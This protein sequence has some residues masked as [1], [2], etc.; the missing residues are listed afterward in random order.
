MKL[1]S[2]HIEAMSQILEDHGVHIE[3]EKV[4]AIASDFKEHLS[5]CSDMEMTPH[6]NYGGESDHSKAERLEKRVKELEYQLGKANGDIR[7]YQEGVKKRRPEA[8]QVY[9]EN[10][11]VKYDI[12]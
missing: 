11:D 10:G 1:Q 6:L 5:A 8:T 2:E 9:I 7:A 4:E 12:A 3:L